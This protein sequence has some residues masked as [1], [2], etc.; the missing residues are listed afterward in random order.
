VKR[1]IT[2]PAYRRAGRL[3][4]VLDSFRK[5]RTDGYTLYVSLEP[6]F[7]EVLDVVRSIDWIP[8]RLSINDRNLG[9]NDNIKKVLRWAMAEGS[10]FNIALEDDIVLAP[11]AFDLAEWFRVLPNRGEYACLGFLNYRSTLEEPLAVLE[12]QD[13]RS[14]GYCF[15]REAWEKWFVPALE[16]VP[17]VLPTVP[18]QHL[19]DFRTMFYFIEN[20]ARTLH[21]ALSRSNHMGLDDGTNSLPGLRHYFERMVMSDGTHRRGFYVK[22]NLFNRRLCGFEEHF[23]PIRACNHFIEEI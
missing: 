1:T 13:F 3:R 23:H 17:R 2:L 12:T 20:G 7:P 19:W 4:E 15:T 21:P 9:L 22:P 8:V 14:W 18:Y 6:G 16:Y 5:N 10:E 11:D